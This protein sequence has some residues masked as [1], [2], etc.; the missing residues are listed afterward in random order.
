M[1]ILMNDSGVL[2]E[3]LKQDDPIFIINYD[4]IEI[5]SSRTWELGAKIKYPGSSSSS[6][7]ESPSE[8]ET[9]A[10]LSP[11]SDTS[12]ANPLKNSFNMIDLEIFPV[13][14]T[15]FSDFFADESLYSIDDGITIY[16]W[17][18]S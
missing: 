15:V 17:L 3:A 7:D 16:F 1:G 8:E 18:R 10:T 13:L 12:K 9:K 11:P 5:K 6:H 4:D 2:E 14:Y